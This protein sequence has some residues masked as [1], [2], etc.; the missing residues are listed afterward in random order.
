MWSIIFYLFVYLRINQAFERIQTRYHVAFYLQIII[1]GLTLW[2]SVLFQ[3]RNNPSEKETCDDVVTYHQNLWVVGNCVFALIIAI[4]LFIFSYRYGS[5]YDMQCLKCIESFNSVHGDERLNFYEAVYAVTKT[6]EFSL[7]ENNL[8][9][10]EKKQLLLDTVV[11]KLDENP[12]LNAET[13]IKILTKI[14]IITAYSS[15]VATA[16]Q[17]YEAG[18]DDLEP[19]GP[20]AKEIKGLKMNKMTTREIDVNL[21]KYFVSRDDLLEYKDDDTG[22]YRKVTQHWWDANK[23]SLKDNH[24]VFRIRSGIVEAFKKEWGFNKVSDKAK[25]MMGVQENRNIT[26]IKNEEAETMKLVDLEKWCLRYKWSLHPDN[27]KKMLLDWREDLAQWELKHYFGSLVTPRHYVIV[28]ESEGLTPDLFPFDLG[29]MRLTNEQYDE[30]KNMEIHVGDGILVNQSKFENLVDGRDSKRY[31]DRHHTPSEV[32]DGIPFVKAYVVSIARQSGETIYHVMLELDVLKCLYLEN[33]EKLLE[34]ETENDNLI[35]DE[36]RFEDE[37]KWPMNQVH[38]QANKL[39][40][41]LQQFIDDGY[42]DFKSPKYNV[43]DQKKLLEKQVNN[44]LQLEPLSAGFKLAHYR[45]NVEEHRFTVLSVDPCHFTIVRGGRTFK[46]ILLLLPVDLVLGGYGL[47][48]TTKCLSHNCYTIRASYFVSM[49]SCFWISVFMT[50]IAY[51]LAR[52]IGNRCCGYRTH[53]GHG[54][55][56]QY[57]RKA[58]SY[59]MSDVMKQRRKK[60][61]STVLNDLFNL[62][63]GGN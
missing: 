52:W 63:S 41:D 44:L 18:L 14:E 61:R 62:V 56:I 45:D 33:P 47:F 42:L 37:T 35:F 39:I 34:L 36:S 46:V 7:Q 10:R 21:G 16:K 31:F 9:D 24:T 48:V 17:F 13:I 43:I 59:K 60:R 2:S 27:G 26:I 23:Q 30:R 58:K 8:D 50:V 53:Q 5:E 29:A 28:D 51:G 38:A 25:K 49:V 55:G 15:N 12:D 20:D 22:K 57:E 32:T 40:A 54:F 19:R 6:E 3:I 11:K 4:T 1:W